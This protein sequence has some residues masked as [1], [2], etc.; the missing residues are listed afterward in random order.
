VTSQT[1]ALRQ[2]IKQAVRE[3]EARDR[4]EEDS[5]RRSSRLRAE[6]ASLRLQLSK[7]R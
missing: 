2:Q 7:L 5:V 4:D 6:A 3:K 1:E